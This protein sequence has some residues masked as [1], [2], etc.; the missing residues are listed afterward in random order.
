MDADT[1]KIQSRN[2][3]EDLHPLSSFLVINR[4]LVRKPLAAQGICDSKFMV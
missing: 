4:G 1:W 3:V 2:P